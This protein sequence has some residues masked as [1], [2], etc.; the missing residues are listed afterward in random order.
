MAKHADAA[1]AGAAQ[2]KAQAMT[3]RTGFSAARCPPSCVDSARDLMGTPL[4]EEP[5]RL[6][7]PGIRKKRWLRRQ[8]GGAHHAKDEL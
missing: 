6:F 2:A 4:G 7:T 1:T 8:V 3:V 5:G